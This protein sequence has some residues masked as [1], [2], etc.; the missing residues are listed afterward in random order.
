[1]KQETHIIYAHRTSIAAEIAAYKQSG[2][3]G[4]KSILEANNE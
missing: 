4:L 2:L 3:A 1:M